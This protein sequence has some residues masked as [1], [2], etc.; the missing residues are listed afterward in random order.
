VLSQPFQKQTV[1]TISQLTTQIR[2]TI[3]ADDWLADCFVSGEI[4][5]FT[6]HSR[7]H[8]YFT[9]KDEQSRIK[10]VMF[11]SRNKI[12]SFMPRDGMKVIVRGNVDVYER[13]GQ[14]QFYVQ[15][16]QPDGV[17]ALYMAFAQLKER[18]QA[19]GLFDEGRKRK[20][21][22]HPRTIGVVTSPTGAV[23]RDIVTTIKRR[24]PLT[25][26][27]LH[28]VLVQ[29]DDAPRSI[30]EAIYRMNQ[31]KHEHCI[32]VLIVGRGGGSLEEL[33]AF[34]EEVVARAIVSSEV[35]VISAVG[36][37]TDVT[38]ADFVADLRA[39]TPTAA[40]ELAAPH[41]DEL[42][43][44]VS[45]LCGRARVAAEVELRE[46]RRRLIRSLESQ[47][48]MRPLSRVT[49]QMQRLDQL[50]QELAL[51]LSRFSQV[52]ERTWADARQRLTT[53]R[54]DA[55]IQAAR[56]RVQF[57]SIRLRSATESMMQKRNHRFVRSLDI[58]DA[59][60]PLH[61]MKRGYALVYDEKGRKLI[62]TVAD[63]SSGDSL[64]IRV[65]N[66]IIACSVQDAFV[67]GE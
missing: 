25:N 16:M 13:D 49:Q 60:S 28:P 7:G 34:N 56:Q 29:G 20:L 11:S 48:F 65:Q 50:E 23:I 36:H 3:Q 64:Q 47:V 5:N 38:I 2:L 14:Y 22:S 67:N 57:M 8:M 46:G 40:A 62:R 43:I 55:R 44:R 1:L 12:L 24:Y 21:P 18:L 19:E 39:P 63:V 42:L 58:L 51:R 26:I 15:D 9:L 6:H 37:E 59:L 41:L 35:P 17:G 4:S 52:K 61:V 32:D 33:W 54:P 66:G 31:L 45:Q 10:A 53:F 30:A 27:L